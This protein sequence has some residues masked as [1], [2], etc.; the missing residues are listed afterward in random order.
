MQPDP[1]R[2]ASRRSTL[3]ARMMSEVARLAEFG[4]SPGSDCRR[5]TTRGKALC[6]LEAAEPACTW[7][8]NEIIT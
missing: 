4:K 2:A 6:P 7:T 3:I 5:S 1:Q 8:S